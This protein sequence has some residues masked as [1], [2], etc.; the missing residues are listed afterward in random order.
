MSLFKSKKPKLPVAV[1]AADI[2]NYS[3][4]AELTLNSITDGV[5]LIDEAG[6]IKFANPAAATMVGY[7]SPSNMIGLDYKA[8]L[9]LETTNGAAVHPDQSKLVQAVQTNQAVTLRDYV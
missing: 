9:R 1:S 8:V 4:L 5:L 6:I 7:G 3:A 2:A